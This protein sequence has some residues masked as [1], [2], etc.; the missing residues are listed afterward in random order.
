MNVVTACFLFNVSQKGKFAQATL[1]AAISQNCPRS[2]PR[3]GL[4]NLPEFVVIVF[5][6]CLAERR[7]ES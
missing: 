2:C 7:R 3:S 1:L 5:L 6:M 4:T